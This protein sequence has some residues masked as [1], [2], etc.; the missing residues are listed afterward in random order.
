M[1]RWSFPTHHVA[2][3]LSI[4]KLTLHDMPRVAQAQMLAALRNARY[5]YLGWAWPVARK[6]HI[7]WVAE[8]GG[9]THRGAPTG[10]DGTPP[11]G[12]SP[13]PHQ[14]QRRGEGASTPVIATD[15]AVAPRTY[16]VA[17]GWRPAYA[18]TVTILHFND[19][20]RIA[21]RQHLM[22]AGLYG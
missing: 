20:D 21:E 18:H 9:P 6:N 10:P 7:A 3:S 1:I 11:A 13:P 8:A 22:T 19:A 16:V 5:G 14:L 4:P 17:S 12:A 2:R 15:K